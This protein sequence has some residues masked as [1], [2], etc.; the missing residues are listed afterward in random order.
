MLLFEWCDDV[1]FTIKGLVVPLIF[2]LFSNTF[3]NPNSNANM[4]SQVSDVQMALKEV[5]LL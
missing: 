1:Q 4:D 5:V 3:P 2:S